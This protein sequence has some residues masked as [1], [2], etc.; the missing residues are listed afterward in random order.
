MTT[1]RRAA[2]AGIGLACWLLLV[3][4]PANAHALLRSSQPA[5]GAQLNAAP[6]KIVLDFTETPDLTVSSVQLLDPSGATVRSG[7]PQ[8][9]PGKPSD[10][11]VSVGHL[12]KGVYTVTWRAVSKVDGHVTAGSFAFGVGEPAASTSR[13]I[14]KTPT[15][16]N[17]APVSV[18]GRWALYWGIALLLA[19]AVT[20][21]AVFRR[22]VQP[23]DRALAVGWLL[24][25][26]GITLMVL[27]AY[28]T[29]GVGWT[30]LFRSSTGR[31]L[32]EQ[33]V[34]IGFCGLAVA[35][36][37][38]GRRVAGYLLMGLSALAVM[39]LHAWGSHAELHMTWFNVPVQFVHIAA[40]GIWVGGLVWL[41]IA[42]RGAEP[43]ERTSD[44][45]RFSFLAGITLGFVAVTG[46][47]RALDEIGG[48]GK[49]RASLSTSFG[50]ALIIKIGLFIV[51]VGLAARNRYVNVPA[52]GSDKGRASHL[53]KTV[54]AEVLLAILILGTTAVLSQLPPP[55]DIASASSVASSPS[56]V[57]VTGHDFATSVRV[58]LTVTPGVPGQNTFEA[59]VVDFDTGKAVPAK[60]VTLGFALPSRANV[61]G[62]SLKLS[63]KAPSV[64]A[65][66]G[67]NLSLSGKWA[68]TVTV[69]ERT[70]AVEVPLVLQTRSAP[71]QITTQKVPGQPTIY[72]IA[73]STGGKL[74]TYI[75]PGH[76]GINNVHFTFFKAT[77]KEEPIGTAHVVATDPRGSHR[78][79]KLIRFDKGH[80]VANA[81]LSPGMWTFA[82]DA[83]T[84]SGVTVSGHF[85]QKIS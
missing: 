83:R 72:N 11:Q 61:G 19:A 14:T 59:R 52:F 63:R 58:S 33:A 69:Q 84:R 49:W 10:L 7:K 79:V 4:A 8:T 57:V 44:V 37:V 73:L 29:I 24:A 21:R 15:T 32:A 78:P 6:S 18:V 39:W 68:I 50:V 64:W 65:G 35:L 17:P 30:Q 46:T 45:R 43:A 31:N 41:L 81:H 16:P 22:V 12:P 3:C 27:S 48:L 53:S 76:P 62:S 36:V 20:D 80:F 56:N 9:V 40:V 34:G 25:A 1:L 54:V 82:I 60:N 13:S 42:L 23:I 47:M 5:A 75:D 66:T 74:Q 28:S 55:V 70:T 67:T 85:S 77:G 26:A 2:I 51:L 38:V 71:Q